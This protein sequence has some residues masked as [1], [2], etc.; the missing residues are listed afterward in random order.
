MHPL[1]TARRAARSAARAHHPHLADLH[2]RVGEARRVDGI[3]HDP[4]AITIH[5][6]LP[7]DLD[8]LFGPPDPRGAARARL[9]DAICIDFLR[10]HPHGRVVTLGVGL[11]TRHF[12]LSH[13]G[14]HWVGVDSARGLALRARW[15]RTDADHQHLMGTPTSASW[16]RALPPG[17][18]DLLL[19]PGDLGA[20]PPKSLGAFVRRLAGSLPG[21]RLVLDTLSRHVPAALQDVLGP[22]ASVH[23]TPWMPA[24]GWR[25]GL[26]TLWGVRLDPRDPGGALPDPSHPSAAPYTAT[27]WTGRTDPLLVQVQFSGQPERG[28]LA[29]K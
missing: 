12:R 22:A 26:S 2:D 10:R 18:P 24:R 5:A 9:F 11:G 28:F 29:A 8:A 6:L 14:G 27:R 23:A 20:L 16:V 19:A 25:R 13:L 21:A 4:D 1:L 15:I 3:L 7:V 17:G